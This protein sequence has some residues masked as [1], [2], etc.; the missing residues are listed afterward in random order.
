MLSCRRRAARKADSEGRASFGRYGPRPWLILCDW[1]C[2]AGSGEAVFFEEAGELTALR[3]GERGGSLFH[4]FAVLREGARD[5]FFAFGGELDEA[6][7]LIG[8]QV[9]AADEAFGFEAV[10]GGGDGAAGEQDLFADGVDGLRSFVEEQF[11]GGEVGEADTKTGDALEGEMLDGA[12]GLPED[13]PEVESAEVFGR[14]GAGTG[15]IW[16]GE[17]F[18]HPFGLFPESFLQDPHLS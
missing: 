2:L 12:V 3:G 16:G 4:V 14:L 15:G 11:E 17:I 1:F 6:D 8:G 7:A 10:D 13:E 5:E 18:L 9:G